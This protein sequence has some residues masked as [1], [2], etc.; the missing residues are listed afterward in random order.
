MPE[1]RVIIPSFRRSQLIYSHRVL[2]D[3]IVCIPESDYADYVAV[4]I[5]KKR[6][7]CHPNTVIGLCPKRNWIFDNL[8]NGKPFLSL[9]DDIHGMMRT[10]TPA[11]V[12]TLLDSKVAVHEIIDNT[13]SMA[14]EIG[15]KFFGFAN[16]ADIRTINFN[17]PFALT[18]FVNGW[19]MG[20]LPGHGLRL[21]E[22]L[23]G[24]EDYELSLQNAFRHRICF[25]NNRYGFNAEGTFKN[26][27]GLAVYRNN[28]T[29][30]KAVAIL[31]QRYG[32]DV[33]LV[34]RRTGFK[35]Q[36]HVG[37]QK[38]ALNLPF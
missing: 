34:V 28:E 31:Q 12:T 35:T 7:V 11:G 20:F 16:S 27:G 3:Y 38:I 2:E 10:F 37:Y 5:P 25:R 9:D 32:S 29:E 30:K 1:V 22:N 19:S 21:P 4:G 24:K 6:I 18:G 15:A 14:E 36:E 33:V 23:I 8:E 26:T 13:V 17:V